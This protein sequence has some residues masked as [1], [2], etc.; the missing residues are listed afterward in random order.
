MH[1]KYRLLKSP[2]I[3]L[4]SYGNQFLNPA[5]HCNNVIFITYAFLIQ[6]KYCK[7]ILVV[8]KSI[9]GFPYNILMTI[10]N[11]TLKKS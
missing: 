6:K 5:Y 8:S 10:I 11:K 7:S 2:S 1:K 3:Y 9:L 4:D